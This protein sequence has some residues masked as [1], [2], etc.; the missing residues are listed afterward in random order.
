MK[1]HIKV[2][3][4]PKPRFL[5]EIIDSTELWGFPDQHTISNTKSGESF[6]FGHNL[7]DKVFS[8]NASNL[9]IFLYLVHPLT[10]LCFQGIRS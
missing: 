3:I 9:D 2:A 5:S 7:S 10:E 1:S 8:E 6:K 4:R